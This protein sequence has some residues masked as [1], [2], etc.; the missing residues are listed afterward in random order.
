LDGGH[1]P[2]LHGIG[3]AEI[4]L[5]GDKVIPFLLQYQQTNVV[6]TRTDLA[7]ITGRIQAPKDFRHLG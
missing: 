4:Y 1:R 3:F 5:P 6:L 7:T 2:E